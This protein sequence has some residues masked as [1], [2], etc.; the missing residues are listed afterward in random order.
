ML[1]SFLPL[2]L[3]FPSM[4]FAKTVIEASA[5]LGNENLNSAIDEIVK[6]AKVGQ[7]DLQITYS[8]SMGMRSIW[9]NATFLQDVKAEE[10]ISYYKQNNMNF[11]MKINGKVFNED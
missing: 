7:A 1:R 10:F 6:E 2:V 11:F 5:A 9:V 3:F 4:L 8:T